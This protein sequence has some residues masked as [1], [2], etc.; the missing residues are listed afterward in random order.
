LLTRRSGGSRRG[1]QQI[2]DDDHSFYLS[3]DGRAVFKW[4]VRLVEQSARDVLQEV[5]LE[6]SEIDWWLPHQANVRILDAAT[7]AMGIDQS[8]VIQHLERYGNTSAGSIPIA[9]DESVRAGTIQRGEK[10]MM[11]GFGAGLA[12]G[13]ILFRW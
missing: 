11:M 2:S 10:L 8:R 6:I 5:D 12:W 4:A 1:F 7:N 9:L 3:M 13:T